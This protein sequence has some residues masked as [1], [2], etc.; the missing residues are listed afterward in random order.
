M[1]G[2]KGKATWLPLDSRARGAREL[3]RVGRQG[4]Q[5]GRLDN[6]PAGKDR[7]SFARSVNGRQV[8]IGPWW[9]V[10]RLSRVVSCLE[11]W[12]KSDAPERRWRG[13]TGEGR[14][15]PPLIASVT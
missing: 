12:G 10:V 2:E 11:P 9:A 4:R 15:P 1:A 7:A 13:E 8:E 14:I 5:A 3:R 6:N